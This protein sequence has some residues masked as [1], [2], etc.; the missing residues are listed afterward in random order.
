[1][2]FAQD[3]EL[4]ERIMKLTLTK[5]ILGTAT[6]LALVAPSAVAD[7][8]RAWNIHTDGHPNT[9]GMDRF[10]KSMSKFSMVVF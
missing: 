8:W 9:A 6:A 3:F 10:A 2:Q 7:D 1:V 4:R 5:T